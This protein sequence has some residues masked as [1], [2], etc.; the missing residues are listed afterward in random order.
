MEGK[1]GPGPWLRLYS[2]TDC[3]AHLGS[4]PVEAKVLSLGVKGMDHDTNKL[5]LSAAEIEEKLS[6]YFHNEDKAHK[7]LHC[8]STTVIIYLIF[9]GPCII[10]QLIRTTNV[11][12]HV[13]FVFITFC[14]STL[15]VSGALCTHHQECI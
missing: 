15:H 14:G 5:L 7:A 3:G 8:Q 9:V 2:Q 4:Y 10:I 13:A 1:S 12:Q 11:M 6:L